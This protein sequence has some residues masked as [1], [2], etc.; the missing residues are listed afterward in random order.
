MQLN[1]LTFVLKIA[2]EGMLFFAIRLYSLSIVLYI[3]FDFSRLSFA[4]TQSQQ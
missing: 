3:N 1:K 2:K 4:A